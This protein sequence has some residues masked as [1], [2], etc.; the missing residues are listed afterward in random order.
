[1][2]GRLEGLLFEKQ[3]TRVL[4]DVGGVG[5]EVHVP[6]TT[7]A[8]LP[9]P[10]KRVALRIHT[11]L[12]ENALQLYGF[13][14]DLEREVF[15]LLLHASRVGPKL[16]LTV[17]SGLDAEKIL[18]AIRHGN[19]A[20]LQAVSG[21]GAKLA[22]RMVLE[23]RDR[24]FEQFGAADAAMPGGESAATAPD[25]RSQLLS[26]LVNLQ[27]PRSQAERIVDEVVKEHGEDAPIEALVRAALP[28]LSR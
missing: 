5:Y 16:A 23:L 6:L 27:V 25:A 3:P 2:I 1:M 14:S 24:A 15:E 9:D 26:A 11:H 8:R 28:R 4:L 18:H 21:V 19:P 22:Q 13:G 10:G 17:L 20:A 7:F 12:R